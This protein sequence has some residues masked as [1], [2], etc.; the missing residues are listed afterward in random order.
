MHDL[1][2]RVAGKF[3]GTS[4]FDMHDSKNEIWIKSTQHMCQG[5]QN[6]CM[7]LNQKQTLS[8]SITKLAQTINSDTCNFLQ[9]H[10]DTNSG[11]FI[12]SKKIK[13]ATK[14]EKIRSRLRR[15][16]M[17]CE[18]K[19]KRNKSSTELSQPTQFGNYNFLQK[20]SDTKLGQL[21]SFKK[22]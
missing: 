16:F 9:K 19:R 17:E 15:M 4:C 12:S 11:L 13:C 1:G 2:V 8:K 3:P 10:S 18:Q 5:P 14:H 20:H 21:I 6:T 22:N 7:Q